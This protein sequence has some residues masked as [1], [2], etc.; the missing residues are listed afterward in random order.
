MTPEPAASDEL[1]GLRV[2][3][4]HLRR[5]NEEL[6]ATV[7]EL[8]A[9]VE[10]H[11]AH[12]DRLVR[13][14]FG[15]RSERVAGPT[16]FDA[17]PDPEPTQPAA[18]EAPTVLEQST[19]SAAQ[20]RR[21]HG[22]RPRPADLPRERVEIDLTEAEKACPCCKRLRV[23][24]GT[25]LSERLDYRPAS[26]FVR[27]IVRPTYAC[28][29]CERAGDDP[30]MVQPPLPP[31]PIP[32]GTAA[33]GLLAHVIVSKYVD[34]MPLYRQES[35]LARLGWDVT[36]STLCDQILACAAVLEPL[37]R[38]MCDRV[39]ASASLHADD[40]PVVLLAPRRTAHAWVYVGDAAN[41]YIVFDLSVGRSRD[42]PAAFLKDYKGYVHADGYAGYNPVYEGGATH[43]GCWAHARRYFF[44]ARLS[45]PQRAHE[46]LARIRALYA[47]EA[48]A[49]ARNIMEVALAAHRQR[50]AGPI[51]AAFADWLAGQA[52]RV[53]PK[54]AIGEAL[55][56]AANQW[57]SLLV[58]T[59]DGRLTIDNGPAE[60]AIRPLAVGRRNWLHVGGDGGLRPT[61]VLLSVAASVKRSRVNPWVYLK[62]VLT[63]LPARPAGAG[64]ADLLPD[65]WAR[66]MRE[67]TPPAPCAPT[68]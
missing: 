63:E 53:L 19:E 17:L 21:G 54:S 7:A 60:Q 42:A 31:E 27:Q 45:D 66:A 24:I 52:P 44:D 22:R 46:A 25:D 48:D 1:A 50:H 26:L 5:V 35:I 61:A 43:V 51:L 41:P 10:K 47:V 68:G 23:R 4:A 55:T 18:A 38:L 28:R 57:P 3:T 11:Q 65:R 62:H 67:S 33:A 34:H 14:T 8:R 49:K 40:T 2:E 9:T 12:I 36:R 64:L 15:R 6:L 29:F 32:G 37:Y 20:R 56:Y 59:R 13:M 58:Y 39:R 16:L 30:Q